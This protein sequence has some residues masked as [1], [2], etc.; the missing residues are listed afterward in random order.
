MGKNN[1]L[2]PFL[3]CLVLVII[4]GGI[5][6]FK[7]GSSE[8]PT[9]E[10]CKTCETCPEEKALMT[11]ELNSWGEN[12]YDSSE[13]IFTV[14]ITNYGYREGKNIEVTCQVFKSDKEGYII[15]D[16]VAVTTTKKSI[17]NVASTSYKQ[18]ELTAKIN[19]QEGNTPTAHCFISS[20]D[21]CEV[22]YKRVPELV[23][24]FEGN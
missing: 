7:S 20:C 24:I 13:N 5:A 16:S 21:S 19:I 3:T 2:I 1:Y 4:L 14:D 10:T 17:G 9:C 12:L 22:L 23:E 8:C 6:I 11:G 18:V 15:G